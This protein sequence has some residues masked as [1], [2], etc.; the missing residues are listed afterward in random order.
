MSTLSSGG[1]PGPVSNGSHRSR[2]DSSPNTNKR[3]ERMHSERL[4]KENFHKD[5]AH[6]P[7]QSRLHHQH[8]QDH[9]TTTVGEY[10]LHHLFTSFI[11][12]ADERINKCLPSTDQME[13]RIENIL[14]PGADPAFDQLIAAL[15]HIVR[16]KPKPLIDSLMVW[17]RE[18]S[19]AAD[20]LRKELHQA[21][22]TAQPTT[23]GTMRRDT[24]PYGPETDT[25]ASGLRS[26]QVAQTVDSL[27]YEAAQADR[28]SAISV[29]ILCRVLIEIIGQSTLAAV[30]SDTAG[31][32]EDVIYGQLISADAGALNLHPLKLANWSIFGQL[33]GV[34]S[35]IN[36]EKVSDRFVTDLERY[37][38][39]LSVKGHSNREVESKTVLLVQSMKWLRVKSYPEDAWDRS[40]DLI[41]LLASFFAGVHGQHI[42]YAYCQLFE[43]LLL[44]IAG[45][46]TSELN[47]PKWR[48]VIETIKPRLSQMLTKPKHWANAFPLMSILLCVSPLEAFSSQWQQMAMSLQPKLKERSTRSHALKALCRLVW[49]Y[50]YKTSDTQNVTAKRLDDIIKM[51]FQTSRRSH[52]STEEAIAE[53]LIQL[54]RI[55][56]F[57]HQDLC[58]RNIIFPLMNSEVIMSGR[59]LK[60]DSLDPEKMVI[61][62][63]AFLAIMSDLENGT[64][65]PFPSFFESDGAVPPFMPYAAGAGYMATHGAGF[66]RGK[67][68]RLSKPVITNGFGDVAKESYVK[69]CKIL[70]EITIICDNTFGGQAVLDE[71]F[72]AHQTP[73]T[74]MAEAFSFARKDDYLNPTDARQNFYDLLHV[75]V[76]ALPR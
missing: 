63:R 32:L 28:R 16:Q 40:C 22:E 39:F 31:R 57:K 21:K 4:K 47:V 58:F 54:I 68:E 42:K 61:G 67:E 35:A 2:D 60:A 66:G 25:I 6:H 9:K 8:L 70:G 59:D 44:P 29:Y 62:I 15:G 38:K 34:M 19:K 24:R 53:P 1:M 76:Q 48:E 18:K 71:R 5:H 41:Q 11:A 7:S 37:Q 56:G 43:Y 14:G 73:K 72:S 20:R 10:A 17:R 36:F 51:V 52:V 75:A 27:N 65:P 3:P 55:I 69:F 30:T 74:P 46:A 33:L 13:P 50:I 12:E 64:Q 49:R 26:P 45:K 23:N